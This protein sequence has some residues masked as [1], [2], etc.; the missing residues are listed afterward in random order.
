M[1]TGSLENQTMQTD[2]ERIYATLLDR[3]YQQILFGNLEGFEKK[4]NSYIARCPFHEDELS[5]LVIYGDR[6]EYFCFACS[7]R[8]DWLQYMQMKDGHSFFHALAILGDASGI[9]AHG[10]DKGRW[11]DELLRCIVLQHVLGYFNALLFSRQAEEVLHYLYKRGYTVSEVEGSSL[12]FFPGFNTM[13]EYLVS[14]GFEKE[15]LN[16]V[17]NV[18]WNKEVENCPLVIPYRDTCGRLMGLYGRDIT[19]SGEDAYI[20]LTDVTALSDVPYLMYKS[21][22]KDEVILVEG[23][24]DALLM[25][26][27]AEKP[28][29][30][31]GKGGLSRGML[32]TL[33]S[34]GTKHCILALGSSDIQKKAT[35]DAAE[36]IHSTGIGVSVLPIEGKYSD[37]DEFIRST[38]IKHF[39]KLLGKAHSFQEWKNMN[40]S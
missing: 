12:G 9:P 27:I 29:V 22:A 35:I 20:P 18:L 23:F 26:Q 1:Y 4:D 10:Y 28:V 5:T 6:P 24:F 21:R 36:I 19:L 38:S 13:H 2:I 3:D 16:E 37:M 17:L 14:G 40:L 25:D 33:V 32:D 15:T 11:D 34:Y 7:A 8:G 31:I 30:S 39:K